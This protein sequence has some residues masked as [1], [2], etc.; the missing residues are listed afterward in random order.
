MLRILGARLP[1]TEGR[2]RRREVAGLDRAEPLE[3]PPC[4]ALVP[5]AALDQD[6]VVDAVRVGRAEAEV[7]DRVDARLGAPAVLVERPGQD[8]LALDAG[9]VGVSAACPDER[10]GEVAVEIQ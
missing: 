9:T 7:P 4:L 1:E 5:E 2:R 8:V 3:E 6:A 10:R